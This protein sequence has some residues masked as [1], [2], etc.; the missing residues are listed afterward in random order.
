MSV[1]K[2]RVLILSFTDHRKDPRV[3]RQ[4]EALK[5]NYHVITAGV[6]AE[7]AQNTEHIKLTKERNSIIEKVKKAIKL[8]CRFYELNYWGEIIVKEAIGKLRLIK[9]DAIV[10]NDLETLPLAVK[11]AKDKKIKLYFDAH[12]YSPKEFDGDFMFDFFIADYNHYLCEKYLPQ[13]NV[14]TTVCQGIANEYKRTFGVDCDVLTNTPEYA[15][16]MPQKI[17]GE[18]IRIIHHGGIN[19]SRKIENMIQMVG[20]KLDNRFE[21]DLMLVN[22]DSTLMD[23]LHSCADKYSNIRII[24][25]VP[26]RDITRV[27]NNYDI[28]LYLLPSDSFNN[29]LALPNKIFEFIQGRLVVAIWPSIEMKRIVE[30]HQLGLV[31]DA[32]TVDAMAEKLNSL[33]VED[34]NNFKNNSH[35]AALTFNAENNAKQ[36]NVILSRL[37]Q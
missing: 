24:K 15:D 17:S 20:E 12:E 27:I 31:A 5:D 7:T 29:N 33:T 1:S 6:C 37:C 2:K 26:M 19:A 30:E 28:G 11:L 13:V 35:K 22:N 3:Y 34:I 14:L 9:V 10:A 32:F 8:K 36:L 18:I 21:M 4:I 16:L 23:F 25:P